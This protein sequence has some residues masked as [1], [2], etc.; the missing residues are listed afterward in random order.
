MDEKIKN[1]T[2]QEELDKLIF[3]HSYITEL[4]KE[5]AEKVKAM[6]AKIEAEKQTYDIK[7][8]AS[9]ARDQYSVTVRYLNYDQAKAIENHLNEVIDKIL[10]G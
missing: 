7:L 4:E 6:K 9:T 1:M 10:E 5:Y 3:I 2:P 8:F